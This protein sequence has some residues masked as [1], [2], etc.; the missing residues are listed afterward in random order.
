MAITRHDPTAWDRWAPAFI[1]LAIFCLLAGGYLFDVAAPQT[2]NLMDKRWDAEVRTTWD[3]DLA[4]I[5]AALVAACAGSAA[6]GLLLRLLFG[7][8]ASGRDGK[9]IALLVLGG[10]GLL[11]TLWMSVNGPFGG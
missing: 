9:A 8:P 6:V 4:R 5:A 2:P 3:L 1:V 7:G 10:L 11:I